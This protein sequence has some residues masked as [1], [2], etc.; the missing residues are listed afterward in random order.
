MA[1]EIDITAAAQVNEKQ[2]I[3]VYLSI[4]HRHYK[5]LNTYDV[6]HYSI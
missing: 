1:F 5:V 6:V 3:Y 4:N 2:I